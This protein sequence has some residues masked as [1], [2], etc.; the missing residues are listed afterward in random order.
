[1]AWCCNGIR[2]RETL[3]RA[4]LVICGTAVRPSACAHTVLVQSYGTSLSPKKFG[5]GEGAGR[6]ILRPR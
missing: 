5:L 1:M 2:L 4:P 3:P 6:R